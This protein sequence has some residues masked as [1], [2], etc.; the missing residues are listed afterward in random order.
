MGGSRG[1]CP[2]RPRGREGL[3]GRPELEVP[4]LPEEGEGE[5][6]KLITKV[7]I[8]YTCG[9]VDEVKAETTPWDLGLLFLTNKSVWL[10]N[11]DKQKTH[12]PM[13]AINAVGS[14]SAR[15]DKSTTK[16]TEVLNADHI[17]DVAF[18]PDED[19]GIGGPAAAQISAARDVL[20]AI[21][22]QLLAR[23]GNVLEAATEKAKLSQSELMRKLTVLLKLNIS[24]EEQL[25]YLLGVDEKEL[26]SLFI[27][28]SQL[29]VGAV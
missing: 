17:M 9:L 10:V 16:F 3:A 15:G 5:Q 8:E 19:S 7:Q 13:D 26:V 20:D 18:Q 24:D 22:D 11:R 1:Y 2:D 27:E 4:K 6:E 29:G 14:V 28:R 21:R 23:A 12:L 25:S